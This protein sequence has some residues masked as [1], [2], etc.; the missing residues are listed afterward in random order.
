ME[1]VKYIIQLFTVITILSSCSNAANRGKIT[2]VTDFY[3]QNRLTLMVYMAADNDLESY[4]LS[5]LRAM[6]RANRKDMSILV[7]LDRAEG[8][9]ETNGNW[10]DTRLYEVIHDDS[11]GSTLKSKRISCPPL[12]LSSTVNT[13]LDMANPEVLKGFIEFCKEKYKAE[14]Y[15]LIIWGHGTGWRYAAE[16]SG[17]GGNRAVAI[18]D[19]TGTYMSVKELGDSV[20]DKGLS[21]IGFDTC[22]GGVIENVYELKDYAQYTVASP[23][24]TPSTGWDYKSFLEE[25]AEGEFAEEDIALSMAEN[26]SAGAAVFINEKLPL[27]F[28]SFEAFSKALAETVT[29]SESQNST[30]SK[31][32]TCKS[33]CYTQNPCDLYLDIFSMSEAYLSDTDSSLAQK[34]L[35]LKTVKEELMLTVKGEKGG[36]GVHLIPKSSSGSLAP[37]HSSDYV[38]DDSRIDQGAFIKESRWWV[39]TKNGNSESFLD[40]LFYTSY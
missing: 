16:K 8:Y 11:T 30:L 38:K 32:L 23:G 6:E 9:D 14:K 3:D 28:N 39:P 33:Y 35:A 24:I 17:S 31:L 36:C 2:D 12:G 19:H 18:D 27:L 15:A 29:D 22:F 1:K 7:L 13:E 21:V 40:K 20:K 34:A 37:V 4:A 26:A 10:T 25:I 5:N